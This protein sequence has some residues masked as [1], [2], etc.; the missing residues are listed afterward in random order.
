MVILEVGGIGINPNSIFSLL[1][2]VLAL[3]FYHFLRDHYADMAI[4][5]LLG[6]NLIEKN[7]NK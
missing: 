5:H 4:K 2:A 1:V 3:G 7:Q 6:K